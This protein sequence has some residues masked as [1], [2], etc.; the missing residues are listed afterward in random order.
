[1]ITN[2]K[3]AFEVL[4]VAL[5]L[6]L[7]GDV[8]LR[9]KPWG[10]NALLFNIAFVAAFAVL[11][12]RHA[13]QRL[14]ASTVA[15]MGVQ[16]FFA[17]MF[18][19]RDS[20]ELLFA[21][22]LAI[23]AI[24]SIQLLPQLG[25]TQRLAG[26]FHYVIGL[27][28][29][30]LSAFLAPF[31]LLL[32]DIE[33]SNLPNSGWRKHAIGVARGLAIATPLVL[34]FGG[35]F[36]AADSEYEGMIQRAFNINFDTVFTHILMFSVFTWL[37]AG[38]LRGAIISPLGATIV[39]VVS[40]EDLKIHTAR[41]SD[42]KD[43]AGEPPVTLPADRSVVEHL[44]ISDPPN[45]DSETQ[46][47][48]GELTNYYK[49]KWSWPDIKN[50]VLP[51]AFT[52]GTTE[53]VIILGVM[54]LLFLS[55]VL[56]QVPYLF[57]GMDLVQNTPDFKLAIYARRGFGELVAVSALVLPTLLIGQWLIRPEAKR[58]QSF[59][60]VLSG[61][62]IALLFVVMASA[63]QRLVLL[64]GELGYG[65][66][67]VRFYPMVFMIWLAVVFVWFG[68]TVLRGHRNNFAWGA[69]WSAIIVLG[70]T[71]L[72][73]PDAS[74]TK[75]NIVLAEHGREFDV[76]YNSR[77]SDDALPVLVSSLGSLRTEDQQSIMYPV[78]QRYCEMKNE[79]DLR[80]WNYSRSSAKALIES[81]NE[82]VLE[83]GDCAAW[84]HRLNE[85]G[86][87]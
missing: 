9:A 34:I 33:W 59:F 70:A 58:T 66:T 11:L 4:K 3:T 38:Y 55:F 18:V 73:N 13:P 6:G 83:I 50:S 30:G 68:L 31:A 64:T 87:D 41:F 36:M 45:N 24:L 12:R 43:E 79:T 8:L 63:T 86:G 77:L 25:V 76:Y 17:A 27:L 82:L 35:L 22:T 49:E 42:V 16:I 69:L 65:M 29:S 15:L 56:Y 37:S 51:K 19:W 2:S 20:S 32:T 72:L 5:P 1:M 47:E 71:N 80:S 40:D 28:W 10:L 48:G 44:N 75:T 21:D 7:I 39:D 74:I 46:P 61:T 85:E 26:A 78:A 81:D 67:T 23:I 62:Q 57:G 54:N 53:V 84:G 52:L 14:N 60:K